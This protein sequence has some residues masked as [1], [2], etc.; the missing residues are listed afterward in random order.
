V[1][2]EIKSAIDKIKAR[3]GDVVF[4][5]TPASGPME[6]AT[7][8]AYPR[9]VYWDAL[10]A[11]T[12][13]PGIHYRDYPQTSRFVCPEWSHLSSVDALTYTQH[14]ARILQTE[15]GWRFPRTPTTKL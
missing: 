7:M 2:K 10:L 8:A 14:L 12:G 5:R 3:G 6:D 1:F 15:K 11:Y 4:I 13:I 9:E